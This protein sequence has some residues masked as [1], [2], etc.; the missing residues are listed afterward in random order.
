MKKCFLSFSILVV[1]CFSFLTST[2][3][4]K[5][6]VKQIIF[7]QRYLTVTPPSGWKSVSLGSGM[8]KNC[9]GYITEDETIGLAACPFISNSTFTNVVANVKRNDGATMLGKSLIIKREDFTT[10]FIPLKK[11]D[12]RAVFFILKQ[13]VTNTDILQKA[14]PLLKSFTEFDIPKELLQP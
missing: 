4:A 5:D 1:T 2:V 13:T 11:R 7:M 10:L 9:A 3:L 8:F 12:Y 14:Q 6:E